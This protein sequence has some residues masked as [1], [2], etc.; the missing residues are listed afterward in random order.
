MKRKKIPLSKK[1]ITLLAMVLPRVMG[2]ARVERRMS[3][4]ARFTR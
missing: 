3:D 1:N 4:S 2:Q